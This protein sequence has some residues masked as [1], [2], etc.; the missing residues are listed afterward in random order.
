[1]R[2]HGAAVLISIPHPD[3]QVTFSALSFPRME[4][5][6]LGSE[7]GSCYPFDD[8]SMILDF[9]RQGRRPLEKLISHRLRLDEINAAFGLMADQA[10]RR[11]LLDL[12][13]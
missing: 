13:Q 2:A 6:V 11:V 10:S 9:H 4:R 1:M 8:F 12:R 3:A 5:R 7:Y